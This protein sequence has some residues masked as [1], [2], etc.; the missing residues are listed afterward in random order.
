MANVL[1]VKANDRP[2]DQ[3]V[4]VRMYDTF[5]KTYRE[6]QPGD[7]ITEVDLF[8]VN[9]PYYG[10]TAIT[11]LYKKNQGFETT[12]EEQQAAE[13]ANGYLDQFLAAD[14]VIFAFPLWNFTIPAPLSTYISYLMQAGKTFNYSAEGPVGLIP[15]KK[16]ALL[17]ARGGDYSSEYM[18]PLEMAVHYM[19][20]VIGFWGIRNPETV[21][22]E[23]HN[24]YQ[25]RANEII[26]TG[27]RQVAKL[28]AEF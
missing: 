14:K 1:F 18:A 15:D 2:A 23:G 16:V 6:T 9:L 21:I 26:E 8:S 20:N 25:D 19:K 24:Q 7:H 5:L 10:N 3:A 28:A 12:T 22:I 11:G 17:N 4:S 27:L 13:I